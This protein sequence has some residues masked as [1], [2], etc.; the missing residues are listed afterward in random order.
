MLEVYL[1]YTKYTLNYSKYVKTIFF[2]DSTLEFKRKTFLLIIT[3]RH[4]VVV[5]VE[6]NHTTV[7]TRRNHLGVTTD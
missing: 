2:P 5:R 1:L 4:S 3:S 6:M 7:Y